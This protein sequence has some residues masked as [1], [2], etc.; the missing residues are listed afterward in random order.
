M[1]IWTIQS[2]AYYASFTVTPAVADLFN[3]KLFF[4][5]PQLLY[6]ICKFRLDHMISVWLHLILISF[7][8][9]CELQ[10]CWNVLEQSWK[11]VYMNTTIVVH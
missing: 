4:A 9:N 5:Q 1:L 11:V 6:S 8:I 3:E 10:L 2:N 7:Q